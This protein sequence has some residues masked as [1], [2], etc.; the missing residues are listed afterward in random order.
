MGPEW[1]RKKDTKIIY[2]VPNKISFLEGGRFK[3]YHFLKPGRPAPSTAAAAA[4]PPAA[5]PPA[6]PSS[7]GSRTT[8]NGSARAPTQTISSTPP[9]TSLEKIHC[10]SSLQF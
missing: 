10:D 4:A 1:G 5:A 2:P 6:P 8:T 9:R 3:P 7:S